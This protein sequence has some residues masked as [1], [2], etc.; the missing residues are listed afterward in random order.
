MMWLTCLVLSI[1]DNQITL[2]RLIKFWLV[3]FLYIRCNTPMVR[4]LISMKWSII[5][6]MSLYIWHL[7]NSILTKSKTVQTVKLSNK[8]FMSLVTCPEFSAFGQTQW[9][10]QEYMEGSRII[11]LLCIYIHLCMYV[12][13]YVW[14]VCIYVY[15]IPFSNY[16]WPF[17][18]GS[19]NDTH[20][21]FTRLE[22]IFMFL[23]GSHCL[24][25]R[26]NLVVFSHAFSNVMAAV[27]PTPYICVDGHLTSMAIYW[28]TS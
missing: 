22:N 24:P 4:P 14:M 9:H 2:K 5:S 10:I 20:V 6:A 16:C 15:T 7:N 27:V 19:A 8:S 23:I 21:L 17:H 28:L 1:S 3:N 13:M 11:V 12:W 18:S 26:P 25:V